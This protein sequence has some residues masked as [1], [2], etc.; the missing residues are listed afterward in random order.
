MKNTSVSSKVFWWAE[1]AKYISGAV[2]SDL[3]IFI[4]NIFLKSHYTKTLAHVYPI[5][6][7][8]FNTA[9]VNQ[10]NLCFKGNCI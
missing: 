7:T 9:I 3:S 10:M 1:L 4:L 2:S 6:F 5:L 8:C